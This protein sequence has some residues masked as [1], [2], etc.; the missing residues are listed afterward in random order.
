[1]EVD[2]AENRKNKGL[3]RGLDAFFGGELVDDVMALNHA[4]VLSHLHLRNWLNRLGH[5]V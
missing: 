3:G 5:R 4:C 1:M 2:V